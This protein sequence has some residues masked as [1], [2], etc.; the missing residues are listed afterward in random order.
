MARKKTTRSTSRK[1]VS[2]SRRK[3]SSSLSNINKAIRS[4][5]PERKMDIL[6]V[7]LC[8]LGVV[9]LLGFF[10][11]TEGGLTGW[12]VRFLSWISGL[13]AVLFPFVL[14][15]VGMWFIVRNE[16]RFPMIS[17]ERLLGVISIYLNS[18]SWIHWFSGGGWELAAA[19]GGGGSLG[20]VFEWIFVSL[21]GIWG[22]LVIL[23]AWSLVALAF[24]FDLSIP[25]LFRK[26]TGPAGSPRGI[27]G[28]R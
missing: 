10:G 17:V 9:S 21:F 25:D 14:I 24:T 11:K 7:F 13:G 22:A 6:G 3:R 5:S 15:I 2:S 18:L 4:L 27:H 23:I 28:D 12:I 20:A 19:G 8:I 16:K 1:S 26:V